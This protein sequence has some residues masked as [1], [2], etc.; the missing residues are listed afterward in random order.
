MS[1]YVESCVTAHSLCCIR[2]HCCRHFLGDLNGVP[3][4]YSAT[5]VGRPWG[6]G[7]GTKVDTLDPGETLLL[8]ENRP[9]GGYSGSGGGRVCGKALGL[10]VEK[11]EEGEDAS[12]ERNRVWRRKQS[13]RGQ[14]SLKEAP[15]HQGGNSRRGEEQ[16]SEI[17]P[18]L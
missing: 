16:A 8:E 3:D 9:E 10:K 6:I 17:Q 11:V 18:R 2:W 14:N 7:P 12:V 15:A 5:R 4:R 13:K 1:V